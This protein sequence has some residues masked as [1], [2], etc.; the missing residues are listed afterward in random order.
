MYISSDLSFYIISLGCSKNLVDSERI[1]GE[2][3]S[4]GFTPAEESENSDIIII[5]TCGFIQDAKE[6]SI[7]VILDAL[8]VKETG[9]AGSKRFSHG[10]KDPLQFSRKVVV[11]GCLTKRYFDEIQ[12]EIPE[13]DFLYGIPDEKFVSEICRKFEIQTGRISSVRENFITVIPTHTLKS[14]TDVQTT[15]VTVPFHLSEV[16]MCRS[17]RK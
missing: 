16:R 4:A 5:N 17:H 1:N 14:L 2:L 11:T 7:E 8:S 13:I 10:K 6:E 15:A 12:S 3:V 9:V